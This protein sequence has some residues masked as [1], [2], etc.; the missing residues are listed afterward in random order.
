MDSVLLL[1]TLG[2]FIYFSYILFFGDRNIFKLI[3]KERIKNNLEQEVSQL[4]LENKIL[5][6]TIDF[7]K[8][9]RFFIEKKAREDLGLM[10]KDEEIYV[11]IDENAPKRKKEERWIDKV[12]RKYQE[13][14][15]R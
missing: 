10:K 5:Q 6:D 9:D 13:F 12:K 15:L 8:S 1:I 3:Q 2:L 11:I 14:K 7:L 4:Q